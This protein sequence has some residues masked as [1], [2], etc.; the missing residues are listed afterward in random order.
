MARHGESSRR[1]QATVYDAVAGRVGYEGFIGEDAPSTARDTVSYS[2]TAVPPD[3]V[4]F[5]RRGAPLRFEE[6]DIYA[7]DRHLGPHQRLPDS[8]LLKTIHTYV[9]DFYSRA[10]S[11]GGKHDVRSMDETALLA[12][13]ILLEAAAAGALGKTGDLAFLEGEVDDVELFKT[14][15]SDQRSDDALQRSV[16]DRTQPVR[17]AAR[18]RSARARSR[19][20]SSK[21]SRS[22]SR[23]R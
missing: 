15:Q 3:E 17:R 18:S 8:D 4:L 5:R 7:A 1:K 20:E 2:N 13:G 6:D 16:I 10:M 9:S 22:R 11:D 14:G 21:S 19:R 23:P 12:I